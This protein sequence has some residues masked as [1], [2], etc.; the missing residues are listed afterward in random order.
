MA[1]QSHDYDRYH[2]LKRLMRTRD[3]EDV[4][5]DAGPTNIQRHGPCAVDFALGTE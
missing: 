3:S 1:A 4:G 5:L 2:T